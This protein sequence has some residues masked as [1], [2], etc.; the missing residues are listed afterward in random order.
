[1]T[2]VTGDGAANT[3]I[4]ESLMTGLAQ[5]LAGMSVAFSASLFGIVAAI[6]MTLVGVF[7]NVTDRRVALMVQ[8]EAF[9][10]NELQSVPR[11][12]PAGMPGR[13]A[14]GMHA[15]TSQELERMLSGFGASVEQ[16]Q[17]SVA[18]FEAAL[19]NFSATTRDFREFNYRL[20]DNVQRM[21]LSFGDLSETLKEHTRALRPRS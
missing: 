14:V 18:Q 3:E 13:A 6:I 10:D 20:K 11:A 19:L 8:I 4:T 21:S 16:L 17:Q 15:A 9:L 12:A 7:A 1:V 2:L 5:A